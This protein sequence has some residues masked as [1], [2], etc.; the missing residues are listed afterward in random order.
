MTNVEFTEAAGTRACALPVRGDRI[1]IKLTSGEFRT[2]T[3][4]LT[5]EWP[6][7]AF[8]AAYADHG[9]SHLSYYTEADHGVLWC[10]TEAATVNDW[11]GQLSF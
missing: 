3:V 4:R 7:T 1:V 2:V 10:R 5:G 11:T 9:T 8:I 6:A